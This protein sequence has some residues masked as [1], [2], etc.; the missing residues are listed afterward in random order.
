VDSRGEPL[1]VR[2]GDIASH[3]LNLGVNAR[4]MDH[5]N[6]NL[7]L[8]YVGKRKTGPTTTV[9]ENPF[10]SIDAYAVLNGALTYQNLVPG[11]DLQV[12][13]NNILNREYFHPGVQV[14]DGIHLATRLPQNRRNTMLRLMFAF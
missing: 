7:R 1:E 6:V 12:T 8:N 3:R 14:A 9:R 11:L 4:W 5:L 13:V 2:I 10:D